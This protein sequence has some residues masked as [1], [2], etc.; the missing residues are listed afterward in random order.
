MTARK[1]VIF[2]TDGD[3]SAVNAVKVAADT[4]QCYFLSLSKGN[5]SFVKTEV[6]IKKIMEAP[7]EPVI[8]LFDDAG[9]PGTGPGE[10]RMK[11]VANSP[12]I[13]V[14]GIIAV[15]AH[16]DTNDWTNVDICVDRFGEITEYGV[17]KA[18]IKETVVKRIRGDTVD[19]LNVH[20]EPIIIGIGDVGKMGG[21]DDFE[22]GAPITKKAIQ[23]IMERSGLREPPR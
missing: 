3:D 2:I 23:I 17:D 18:G 10:K 6:L 7:L 8:I 22:V 16:S 19:L 12:F 4:L 13:Y 9:F 15:A 11:E 1:K 5:P 14:L 21:F 20:D